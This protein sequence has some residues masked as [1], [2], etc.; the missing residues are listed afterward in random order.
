MK[1][2]TIP[3]AL[4]CALLSWGSAS[5]LGPVKKAAIA[6]ASAVDETPPIP[7]VPVFVTNLPAVQT[8]EGSVAVTNLPDVQNVAGTVSV[9]NLPAV[10][11]VGGT[12][13]VG[14]LP[15][16]A[17]GA[18]RVTG[19]CSTAPPLQARYVDLIGGTLTVAPFQTF[20]S[21]P[22]PTAGY[23]HVGFLYEGDQGQTYFEWSWVADNEWF[24]T[25]AD[26][27]NGTDLGPCESRGETSVRQV[28]VVSG[29]WVRI[30]VL[31]HT[32]G[33]SRTVNALGVYLMP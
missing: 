26:S 17:D 1:R 3:F 12:V 14:N 13:S 2:Q 20:I 6:H 11:T 21:D 4:C 10:Q 9:G 23:Q 29:S 27:R 32:G 30:K 8:V 25:I 7:T 19:G 16:D 22:V 28:C 33:D 15:L 31:G 5:A 18:V 24:A